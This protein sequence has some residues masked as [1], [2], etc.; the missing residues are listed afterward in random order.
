MN[1]KRYIATGLNMLDRV[2]VGD[3]EIG[4]YMGG[5]PMYGYAGMRPWVNN[6]EDICYGARV[7]NDF[8]KNYDPWFHNNGIDEKDLL[9]VSDVT[10]YNTLYYSNDYEVADSIFFTGDFKDSAFWRPHGE[11]FNSWVGTNTRGIYTCSSANDPM[12]EQIFQ[13]K[14]THTFKIMWEPTYVSTF[15]TS[16]EA[17]LQLCQKIEM[18]SFNVP[19]GCRIFG[20]ENEKEL[21]KLLCSFNTELI[22]LRCGARGLYVIH[23]HKATMIPSAPVP[24]ETGVVDVTGCGNTSTAGACVAWCEGNDPIMTGIMANVSANLNLR[25]KGP[26]PLFDDLVCTMAAEWA[27]QLYKEFKEER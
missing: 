23:N 26:Y 11:D 21:L 5:I 17:T 25:Q 9:F 13:L 8:F 1:G 27:N 22:L 15:P 10:P 2:V 18:A 6:P 24:K 16:K 3:K 4:I 14:K 12:W 19:E 20:L 7:G